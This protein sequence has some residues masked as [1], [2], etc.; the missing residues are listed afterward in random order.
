M[1]EE[2][3][4][5][6]ETWV[7]FAYYGNDY[8]RVGGAKGDTMCGGRWAKVGVAQRVWRKWMDDKSLD[9]FIE[10]HS[11]IDGLSKLNNA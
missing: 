5:S 2:E 4:S 7:R 6:G 9:S 10:P 8:T 3:H 11:L 1:N